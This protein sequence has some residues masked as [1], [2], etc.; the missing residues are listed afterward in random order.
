MDFPGKVESPPGEFKDDGGP[1][2]FHYFS[3]PGNGYGYDVSVIV[4]SRTPEQ[5]E[6]LLKD[7]ESHPWRE[8]DKE[9]TFDTTRIKQGDIAG[10]EA[11]GR[12]DKP[13]HKT[14]KRWQTY[15]SPTADYYVSVESAK[16]SDPYHAD[17]E[18]FFKSF[19]IDAAKP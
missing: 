10:V 14:F 17:V 9:A 12:I 11:V 8:N 19:K 4:Q 13:D 16:F 3:S 2:R 5:I 6:R 15:S 7:N 1:G 18:K